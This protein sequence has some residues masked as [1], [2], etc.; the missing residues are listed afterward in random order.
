[1]IGLLGINSAL[2]FFIL[3]ILLLFGLGDAHQEFGEAVDN[4]LCKDNDQN[5]KNGLDHF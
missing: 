2:I 3:A 1:M 5:L 4:F